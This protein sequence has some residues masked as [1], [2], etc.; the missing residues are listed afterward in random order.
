[1]KPSLK[2]NWV[3]K[4]TT[5][6]LI[7]MIKKE[8]KEANLRIDRL[9]S[10]GLYEDNQVIQLKWNAYLKSSQ[11]GTKSGKFSIATEGRTRQQLMTQY[12]N[13]R[14]FLAG[15][16]TVSETREQL[17]TQASRLGS[18][19]SN[20]SRIYRIY[21]K[22]GGSSLGSISSDI[23]LRIITERVNAGQSD[24]EIIDSYDRA[25][26]NANTM[27]ELL[28]DFSDSFKYF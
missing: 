15:K 16:T 5:K 4:W 14:N 22:I 2:E 7:E 27:Q 12:I 9:K 8:G 24:D 21:N 23:I 10:L 1:M 19:V 20:V 17:K 13:I 3:S 26:E 11:Y 18:D 28:R 25:L 6:Q